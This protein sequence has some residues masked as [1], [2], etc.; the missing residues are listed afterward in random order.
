MIDR[1]PV[2][3]LRKKKSIMNLVLEDEVKEEEDR[4]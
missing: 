2:H 3:P 4:R 1:L